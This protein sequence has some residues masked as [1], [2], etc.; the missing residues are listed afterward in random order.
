[1]RGLALVAAALL[2]AAPWLADEEDPPREIG[3]VERSES[4]LAQVDFTVVG[5]PAILEAMTAQDFRLK[6]GY[7][8]IREFTLDRIC[9]SVTPLELPDRGEPL[10]PAP[11]GAHYVLYFDQGH[12]TLWRPPSVRCGWSK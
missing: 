4:Q 7:R 8:R 5:D 1:M 10:P 11:V 3:L 12:L 9:E 2:I 6:V